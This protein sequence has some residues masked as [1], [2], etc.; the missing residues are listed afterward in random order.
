[1]HAASFPSSISIYLAFNH[2]RPSSLN[3]LKEQKK[4][5]E[6]VQKGKMNF[7]TFQLV[8]AVAHL[9]LLTSASIHLIFIP[10]H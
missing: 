3:T 2:S 6:G 4:S 5:G 9:Y 8:R 10:C 1:M 7:S